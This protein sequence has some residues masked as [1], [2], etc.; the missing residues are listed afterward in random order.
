M[1]PY[2]GCNGF[3]ID[4]QQT[5]KFLTPTA[6]S[7][8]PSPTARRCSSA[9]EA[10]AD[11]VRD[12][13]RSAVAP[14]VKSV[15]RRMLTHFQTIKASIDRPKRFEEILED[16]EDGGGLTKKEMLGIRRSATSCSRPWAASR[17]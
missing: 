2:P 6:T 11:A 4:L 8:I 1:K 15:A 10:G 9:P 3:I 16:P 12:R 7:V 5:V 17:T 13:R 14:H